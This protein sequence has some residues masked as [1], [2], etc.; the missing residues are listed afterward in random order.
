V[1]NLIGPD[2]ITLLVRDLDASRKFYID[3]IGL[4]ESAEKQ[5]NAT[6]FATQP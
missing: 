2:F 4:K 1:A 3:L 6:A 5:P